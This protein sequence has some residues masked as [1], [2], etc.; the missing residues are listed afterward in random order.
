MDTDQIALM[1]ERGR[2]L[3]PPHMWDAVKRYMLEGIP[4]GS[5]LTALLSNDLI[6]A[7]GRADSINAKNMRDWCWFL[8]NYVP[9]GSYGSPEK[10]AEWMTQF[11]DANEAA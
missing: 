10:V 3:V 11:H 1:I 4:G 5:F 6:G 7:F 9:T 2:G 8:C